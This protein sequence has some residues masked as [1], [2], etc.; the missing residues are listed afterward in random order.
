LVRMVGRKEGSERKV[1]VAGGGV[2]D[3]GSWAISDWTRLPM[4]LAVGARMGCGWS[5]SRPG[6]SDRLTTC[7]NVP[8]DVATRFRI[9][10]S[11]Y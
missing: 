9:W 10:L 7:A 5:E 11:S 6:D 3:V 1:S 4:M 2:V 8:D